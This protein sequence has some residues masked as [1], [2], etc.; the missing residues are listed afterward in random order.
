MLDD[1]TRRFWH[2]QESRLE[3]EARLQDV[4]CW[5]DVA[6]TMTEFLSVWE[7]VEQSRARGEF[8]REQRSEDER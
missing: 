2:E 3:A 1:A 7:A 5:R 8:L 6:S 4:E